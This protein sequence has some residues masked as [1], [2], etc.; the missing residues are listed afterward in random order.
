MGTP[1]TKENRCNPVPNYNCD[2]YAKKVGILFLTSSTNFFLWRDS[3]KNEKTKY[4]PNHADH[5]GFIYTVST[6][7]G[8]DD[9]VEIK[10]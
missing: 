6:S 10:I 5:N 2:G 3:L 4:F 1:I 8:H 7:T 9:A